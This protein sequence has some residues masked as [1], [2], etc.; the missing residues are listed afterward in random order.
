MEREDSSQLSSKS[1][2]TLEVRSDVE[3]VMSRV[4]DA[5]RAMLFKVYTDAQHIP[6]W[7][8]PRRLKTTVDKLELRVGG[9]WRFVQHDV[10]GK[11]FAFSGEFKEVVEPSRLVYTF[12]FEAMPGHV[13][14]ETVTFEENRGKTTVTATALFQN[15]L[16]RDG[17]LNSGMEEGAT[18]SWD[19]IAELL[20]KLN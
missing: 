12:E 20:A 11:Q 17:M 2:A 7:W 9:T 14:V 3:V 18:E 19:R 1:K 8:G 15:I 5:P 16:D 4:F 6:H 13:I 10:N